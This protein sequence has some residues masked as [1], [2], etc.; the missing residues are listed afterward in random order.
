[1]ILLKI[2]KEN[3]NTADNLLLLSIKKVIAN[4]TVFK[5]IE[6]ENS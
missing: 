4:K 5:V 2:V 6:S 3:I 1:M